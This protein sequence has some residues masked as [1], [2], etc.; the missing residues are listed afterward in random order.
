MTGHGGRSLPK[1]FHVDIRL[2]GK[3]QM[4]VRKNGNYTYLLE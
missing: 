2:I 4:W 3:T 1:G